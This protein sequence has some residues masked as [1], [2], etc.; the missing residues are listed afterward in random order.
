MHGQEMATAR[1]GDAVVMNFNE[2]EP[3]AGD[4]V[5]PNS[6]FCLGLPPRRERPTDAFITVADRLFSESY[7][8]DFFQAVHLLERL[9][10]DRA[11]VGRSGPAGEEVVR[12]RVPVSLAFPASEISE[13]CPPTAHR[14][15]AEMSVNFLGLTGPS[16]ILPRHYTELLIRRHIDFRG[17]EKNVL[18]D[19]LD[20]FNH[21]LISLFYR[22]WEKYRF[23]TNFERGE[24]LRPVPDGFTVCLRS[25]IGLAPPSLHNRLR[26]SARARADTASNCTEQVL[27]EIKDVSLLRYAGI[28][29]QRP[30]SALNLETML[31]DYFQVPVTV[32]QFQ[33]QWLRLDEDD[34]S[35]LGGDGATAVLGTGATVGP[36]VWNVQG[37]FRICLGPLRYTQFCA[38]LPDSSL[39][40][41]RKAFFLLSR[42]VRLF[43]GPEFDFDVQLNLHGSEVPPACLADQDE[44]GP[45][46]GWNTWLGNVAP[47]QITKDAVIAGQEPRWL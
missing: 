43:V 22:A 2:T 26:V 30:R 21:R 7:R 8:F 37:K 9:A 36:R 41:S 15:S 4:A 32:Q 31:R 18:R 16:G 17:A 13:L 10:P 25:L 45:R 27:A 42:L 14:R 40:K 29:S 39:E 34:Q 1:R 11:L 46:L 19:W 47:N 28:L 33:G 35:R 6:D 20:L 44:I 38:F 3:I 5:V 24:H 12:F 23:W